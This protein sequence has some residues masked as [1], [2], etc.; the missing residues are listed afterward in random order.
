MPPS[1]VRPSDADTIWLSGIGARRASD[2]RSPLMSNVCVSFAQAKEFYEQ[3]V[4]RVRREYDPE[5][6]KVR[7]YLAPQSAE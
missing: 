3:F 1:Q 5:K 6:V 2:V 7:S 4:E